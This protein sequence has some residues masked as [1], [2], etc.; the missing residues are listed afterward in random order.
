M[1]LEATMILLDNSSHSINGDYLPTRFQAQSDASTI[2]F[3][4]KTGSNPESE[5]GLMT[6]AGKG[7]EVLVTPT[8]ELGAILTSIHE[9][10]QSGEADFVTSIQVAQL[11]LKHRS[12]KNQRQRLVIFVS[13]PLTSPSTSVGNLEKLAKKIKKN[14]VAV[15]I[16]LLDGYGAEEAEI[17]AA[18]GGKGSGG[19]TT[20]E[21]LRK[22]IEGVN[23]SDD[24]S[25]LLVVPPGVGLLS[26]IL[27]SSP[28]LSE[29][30]PGGFGDGGGDVAAGGSGAFADSG[31][32]DP[33]AD[34]ELAMA[35]RMSLEEEQARQR[36]A[37]ASSSSSTSAEVQAQTSNAA[38]VE[39]ADTADA[40]AG[41]ALAQSKKRS[42]STTPRAKTP[43][44]A[45]RQREDE[46]IDM[47]G[48][49]DAEEDDELARALAL[50]RGDDNA[51]VD[52]D[53]DMEG[54]DEGGAEEEEMKRAL[55][56]SLRDY[57]NEDK[58]QE[59]QE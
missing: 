32:I 58:N 52:D 38:P 31:G 12:N 14:N 30:M 26:D 57:E 48:D 44:P 21:R 45:K 5:V 46:D 35:L 41:K 34:P 11:A 40:P 47:E 42:G 6:M 43:P 20:E 59:R 49:D 22:F 39:D 23:S 19:E 8:K 10:K 56:M 50:S 2:V 54:D 28:I 33:N 51:G 24:N 9:I 37:A 27:I 4:R 17:L 1:P 7:P 3:N 18:L 16:V 29:D 15:D 36:A 25:H 53:V 13:S 55:A